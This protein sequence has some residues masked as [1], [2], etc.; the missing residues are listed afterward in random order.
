MTGGAGGI[1]AAIMRRL[2]ED[3]ADVAIVDI[4]KV[5][6]RAA[7]LAKLSSPGSARQVMAV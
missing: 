5:R 6:R 3:G 1:G 7:A 4:S 2:A